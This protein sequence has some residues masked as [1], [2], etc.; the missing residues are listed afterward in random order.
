MPITTTYKDEF[1]ALAGL[2]NTGWA[3]ATPIAWPNIAYTPTQG[4][5]WVRFTLLPSEAAQASIGSPGDN[6]FMYSGF[7]DIQVFTPLN[8]GDIKAAELVDKVVGI[9]H[10]AQLDGYSFGAGYAVT[11]ATSEDEGWHQKNVRVRYRHY[12]FK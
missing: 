11:V 3:N 5:P 6:C 1:N 12:E 8:S 2:F 10:N 9:F 4:A 7:I